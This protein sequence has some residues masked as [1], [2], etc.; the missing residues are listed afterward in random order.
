MRRTADITLGDWGKT[1]WGAAGLGLSARLE[2]GVLGP[3]RRTAET[4]LGD[5]GKTAWGAAGL[6]LSARVERG[7]LGAC[8]R[9]SSGN[10]SAGLL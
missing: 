7:L 4:T 6:G 10:S 8:V 3:V 2:R 9:Q 5:W 1:A